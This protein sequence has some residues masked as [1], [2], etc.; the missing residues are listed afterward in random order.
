[1]YTSKKP[2]RSPALPLLLAL[3]FTAAAQDSNITQP[4]A[5]LEKLLAAEPL[6]ITQAEI[7]RPKAKGDPA[8]RAGRW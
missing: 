3:A 4:I 5:D 2:A 8:N 6:V 1:M 7:S